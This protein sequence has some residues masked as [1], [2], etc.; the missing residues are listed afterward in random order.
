MAW[1]PFGRC[2]IHQSNHRNH[3]PICII[4]ILTCTHHLVQVHQWVLFLLSLFMRETF[5]LLLKSWV[6]PWDELAVSVAIM[7]FYVVSTHHQLNFPLWKD[8]PKSQVSAGKWGTQQLFL[9]GYRLKIALLNSIRVFTHPIKEMG[10]ILSNASGGARV[11]LWM[12]ADTAHR[13]KTNKVGTCLPVHRRTVSSS[14]TYKFNMEDAGSIFL[15]GPQH[16]H[17]SNCFVSFINE[18]QNT[19]HTISICS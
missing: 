4:L 3:M 18:V 9:A 11:P 17:R 7:I 1:N 6:W 2:I 14:Q 10:I 15:A 8:I 16:I 12:S 19:P 5:L 13:D